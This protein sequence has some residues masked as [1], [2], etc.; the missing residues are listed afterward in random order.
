MKKGLIFLILLLILFSFTLEGLA[1]GWPAEADAVELKIYFF[2]QEDSLIEIPYL[3]ELKNLSKAE[4]IRK[5]VNLLL[6]GPREPLFSFIP[7]GTKLNHI[8]LI[9]KTIVLDFSKEL[10]DYGG[11]SYNVLHIKE[12]LEK[13]IFQFSFIE[14][15]IFVVEGKGEKE[16]VLQP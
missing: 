6:E 15:I 9:G 5:T 7:K 11:G 14:N 10:Q 12:Q 3:V 13:T 4:I 8:I 1:Y 16:G 2:D